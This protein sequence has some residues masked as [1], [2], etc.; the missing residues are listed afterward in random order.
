MTAVIAIDPERF[1]RLPL[2]KHGSH[3][4]NDEAMCVMEAVAWVTHKEWSDQPP[5]VCPV[6]G[7]FM[8]AWNDGLPNDEERTA[9]LK[10]LIPKLINTKGS[11][12]LANRRAAMAA[13]WLVRAQTVAWL[14]LAKLDA[15]A[16]A[17]ASL[18]EITDF[19]KCPPMMPALEAARKGAAAAGAAA[20]A[21]A[22]DAAWAAARA[23]ARDAV[24]D[25]A[26]AA[27][28]DALAPTMLALQHSALKLVERMIAAKDAGRAS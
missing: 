6:I 28:R 21:A 18:P 5:C 7:A 9:L 19:A 20:W 11:E 24:R 17:L 8:R 22:G 1:E 2:L 13:D 15:Q 16:D 23:A 25:A 4:A 14:R 26:W 27:A 12:A 3:K 10:P